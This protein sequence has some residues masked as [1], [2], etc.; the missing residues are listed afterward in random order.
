MMLAETHVLSLGI[1]TTGNLLRRSKTV[2]KVCSLWNARTHMM[3]DIE[4][5]CLV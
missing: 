3:L 2:Q 1:V 5:R 4:S